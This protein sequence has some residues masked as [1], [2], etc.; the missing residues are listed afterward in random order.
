MYIRILQKIEN[1]IT[2]KIYM[3][4][5]R[6]IIKENIGNETQI[7]NEVKELIS[8]DKRNRHKRISK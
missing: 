5:A 2:Y 4:K 7:E 3:A 1:Y 8:N 6:K